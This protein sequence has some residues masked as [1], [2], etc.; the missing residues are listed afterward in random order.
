MLHLPWS[1]PNLNHAVVAV[2]T[3][4]RTCEFENIGTFILESREIIQSFAKASNINSS[5][6]MIVFDLEI[7]VL[8]FV[9]PLAMCQCYWFTDTL[10][11]IQNYDTRRWHSVQLPVD[12][13]VWIKES[14]WVSVCPSQRLTPILICFV[15]SHC[16]LCMWEWHWHSTYDTL[17]NKTLKHQHN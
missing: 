7:I 5:T 3:Y 4:C 13:R 1:F 9:L 11:S 16:L 17:W 15:V 2:Y 10:T 14:V 6:P 8:S 12:L